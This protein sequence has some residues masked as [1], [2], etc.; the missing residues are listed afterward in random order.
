MRALGAIG[1][2]RAIAALT[3]QFTFYEKGE[4][5]WSALDALARIG[6]PASVPLFKRAA[7]GQGSLHPPR[8]R[9]RHRPRRRH[10]SIDALERHVDAPTTSA[11][12]RL[13]AVVRA[14][15]ARAQLRR[16]HRGPDGLGEGDR[17]RCRISVELG[18]SMAPTL[19][20]RLQ[21]PDADVREASPTCSARSATRRSC[22]ALEAAA[23]DRDASVASAAK[24][25]MERIKACATLRSFA[26]RGDS[27]R[28]ASTTARRSTSRAI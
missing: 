21:D 6:A 24:R 19:V 10:G 2:P 7:A 25:A 17:R 4:G 26:L 5:A 14:A 15:E 9:R 3:E 28:V 20:P 16:A 23:K 27:S 18:P 22:P 13:A 8:R 11:M 12:V 1:E